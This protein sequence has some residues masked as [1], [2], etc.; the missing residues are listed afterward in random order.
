MLRP[1]FIGFRD[2]LRDSGVSAAVIRRMVSELED[3]YDDLV[4][5]HCGRGLDPDESRQLAVSELGELSGIRDVAARLPELRSFLHRH[6]LLAGCASP[7]L[8]AG[9]R[10]Q[11]INMDP[12]TEHAARW[13][14]GAVIS[15]VV[16]AAMFLSLQ[17]AIALG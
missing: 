13:M 12:V 2:E 8:A 4:Q 15:G 1:D 11:A 16:T 7:L 9:H 17:F 10:L 3:H 6:P 14:T 5:A